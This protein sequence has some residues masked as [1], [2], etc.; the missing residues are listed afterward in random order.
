[1][2][3]GSALLDCATRDGSRRVFVVGTAKNAGKTVAMRAVAQAAALRGLHVGLTSSGRDGEA[4]DAA[5]DHA[6]PRLFLPQGTVIATA[7]GLVPAHPA[8]EIL[9]TTAWPTAAGNVVFLRV[10][11]PGFFE[12]AGPATGSSMRECV[13]RFSAY[14]CD[15]AIVD[16]ALDRIAALAAGADSVI[17]AAGASASATMEEAV[18]EAQGLVERLQLRAYEPDAPHVRVDGALTAARAA[19]FMRGKRR[20]IVLRDATQFVVSGR[21]A[22]AITERLDVRC[23]RPLHVVAV[24]AASIG[25]DRYFEP[26]AFAHALARATKLPVFDIYAN[27]R[28]EAA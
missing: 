7:R 26:A 3:V 24:A 10:R 27:A 23:E 16:G 15:L 19:E 14:G 28:V 8:A 20:Q 5:G 2:P 18:L 17:V 12:I 22:L 13:D 1:M 4:V 9:D 11:R 21:A 25:P 6:K